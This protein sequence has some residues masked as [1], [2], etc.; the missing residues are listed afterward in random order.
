MLA[1][2]SCFGIIP[3]TSVF[4]YFCF[5]LVRSLFVPLFTITA[6]REG[7]L[8]TLLYAHERQHE[9]HNIRHSGQCR[10]RLFGLSLLI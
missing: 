2:S 4:L 3:L 5:L 9:Q 6:E 1:S 7:V 8:H 10:M